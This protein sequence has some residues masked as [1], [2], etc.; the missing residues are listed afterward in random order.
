M[1]EG[2]GVDVSVPKLR[3]VGSH[4][5]RTSSAVDCNL[6][7]S[8]SQIRHVPLEGVLEGPAQ[9]LDQGLV[10][11]GPEYSANGEPASPTSLVM[12]FPLTVLFRGSHCPHVGK[13]AWL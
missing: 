12:V 9:V 11:Y 10:R 8:A 5:P 1:G 3:G 7:S 4:E 2:L 6:P 13:A